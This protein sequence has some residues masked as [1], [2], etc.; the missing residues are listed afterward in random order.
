MIEIDRRG[1]TR[2]VFLTK[3]R[4]YK[5]PSLFSWKHFLLGLLANIQERQF[6]RLGWPELCPVAWSLPGGW[7]V[8]MPRCR[9]MTRAEFDETDLE[10]LASQPAYRVPAELKIDSWGWLNGRLVAFDYGSGA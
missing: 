1:A 3:R 4:V 6:G 10:A 2:L 8:V 7:L 9:P 5:I